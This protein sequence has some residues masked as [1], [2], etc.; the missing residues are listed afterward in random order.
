MILRR[1]IA[2]L[3]LLIVPLQAA[4]G[5]IGA[6]CSHE[7]GAAARHFGHHAHEHVAAADS[8][9]AA[10][11]D[12]GGVDADCAG[13]HLNCTAVPVVLRLHD[14][15]GYT[16]DVAYEAALI[17]ASSPPQRPERPRWARLA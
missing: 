17:P 3:L 5:A 16:A 6:Y 4:W 9:D 1:W 2:V 11:P 7:S 12:V 10:V 14:P 13:C 8:A 15:V